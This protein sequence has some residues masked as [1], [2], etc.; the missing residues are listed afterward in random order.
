MEELSSN[1]VAIVNHPDDKINCWT[2]IS[3]E[4][5]FNWR[6]FTSTNVD[7]VIFA[8]HRIGLDT[9]LKIKNMLPSPPLAIIGRLDQ[10]TFGRGQIFRDCLLSLP[11]VKN[12]PHDMCK[13]FK[14]LTLDEFLKLDVVVDQC[15]Y[16]DN[17]AMMISKTRNIKEKI[18]T[19]LWL[20]NPKRV[21]T[22]KHRNTEQILTHKNH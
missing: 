22:T 14:Y 21:R 13:N 4:E 12:R 18:K 17:R 7:Y 8:A 2:S 15:F 20:I 19:R 6:N 16:K 1:L 3:I 11:Q 10:Y 5:V 9:W